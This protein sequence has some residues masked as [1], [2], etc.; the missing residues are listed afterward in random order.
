MFAPDVHFKDIYSVTA[1]YLKSR[2][3]K[4]VV[5][6]IDNTLVPYATPV[7]TDGVRRWISDMKNAGIKIV[8]AS[9]NGKERV[10]LFCS[11]LDVIQMYKSKKPLPFCIGR[12]KK[13]YGVEP[14]NVAVIGDQIFTDVLCAKFGGATA[15]H[16][17][18]IN[19]KENK[20]IRFKRLLERPIISAYRKRHADEFTEEEK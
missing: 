10:G 11:D 16:V 20:F 13:E 1:E 18:P 2:A 14:K 12:I 8:I 4:A 19:D 3:V 9:N 15:I 5:L 7:P 17:T 6:D